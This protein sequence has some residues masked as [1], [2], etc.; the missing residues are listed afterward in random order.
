VQGINIQIL[1]GKKKAETRAPRSILESITSIQITKSDEGRDGFQISLALGRNSLSNLMKGGLL[2]SD[3]LLRPSC[4]IIL[5]VFFNTAKKVLLDGIITHHQYNPSKTA[6]ESTLT[7]TGEDV[8]IMLDKDEKHTTHKGS[9]NSIIKNILISSDYANYGFEPRVIDVPNDDKGERKQ[10]ESDLK[11]ILKC[12]EEYS[13]IFYV[14]PSDSPGKNIVYWGPSNRK[15]TGNKDL[16]FNMGSSSNILSINFQYNSLKPELVVGT[17]KDKD[18]D[19][20]EEIVI[21]DSTLDSLITTNSPFA[22]SNKKDFKTRWLKLDKPMTTSEA[23]KRAQD[24]TNKS[25][26]D[27]VTASGEIDSSQYGDV[28]KPRNLVI[29]KGVGSEYA[30]KYYVKSVTHNIKRGEYKQSF[31]LTREDLGSAISFN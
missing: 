27:V 4:R 19:K 29:L 10:L 20:V 18:N 7:I 26:E 12:G 8:S 9:V 22:S 17:I 21:T 25:F 13:C 28:I 31:N 6:G 15:T 14:E 5:I 1:L 24:E 23:Y 16:L 30:G 11:F 2:A 3:D